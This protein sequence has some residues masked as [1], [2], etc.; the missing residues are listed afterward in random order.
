MNSVDDQ[1]KIDLRLIRVWLKSSKTIY[2]IILEDINRHNLTLENFMV[3]EFLYNK[4]PHTIQKISTQLSI[5]SGSITHVVN[6]LEEKGCVNRKVSTTDRRSSNVVLTEAGQK[7]FKEIFPKHVE[8][9]SETLSSLND[10]EKIQLT[11]LLK[12]VGLGAKMND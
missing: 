5:P 3:L 12:K 6:K 4:G 7:L 10:E 8:V 9:L 11:E 2:D 1:S